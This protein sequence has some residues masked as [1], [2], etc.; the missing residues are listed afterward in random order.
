M[1]QI[2]A[3]RRRRM[4]NYSVLTGA[5]RLVASSIPVADFFLDLDA[6][7]FDFLIEGGKRDTETISRPMGSSPARK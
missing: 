5:N 2:P 3:G 7:A 6:E 4:R 1:S